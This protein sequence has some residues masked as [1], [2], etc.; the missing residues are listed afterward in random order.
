MAPLSARVRSLSSSDWRLLIE[1]TMVVIAARVALSL[2]G[3]RGA[4]PTV[5]HL[6]GFTGASDTARMPWAVACVSR[7]I[8]G[9]SCLTQALALQAMLARAGRACRIEVGVAR[10]DEFEAHAWVVCGTEI[11]L[12]GQGV[13]KFRTVATFD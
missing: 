12:G 3:V 1:T 5:R 6:A 13:G 10:E 4:R 9:A 7:R 11:V 2:T 8:P